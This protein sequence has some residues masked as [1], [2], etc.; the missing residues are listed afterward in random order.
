VK[1]TETFIVDLERLERQGADANLA[2]RLMRAA[3]DI[4]LAHWGLRHFT[5]K[6]PRME[7]HVQLG[8][9]RYF[10]RLQ[11][12]HLVEAMKLIAEVQASPRFLTLLAHCEPFAREAFA[13]LLNYL[14]GAPMKSEF[15]TRIKS[16]RNKAAFHYDRK[17][18]G[19][20]LESRASRP[21]SR[22]S[23]ITRASEAS[24]WRS[25]VADDIEDTILCRFLWHIPMEADVREE[26]NKIL[27][28][29]SSLCRDY[30]DVTGE[31]TF[32]FMRDTATA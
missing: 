31:L 3:D 23:S 10:V 16:I 15:D 11:C 19:A 29:A 24:M 27:D 6:Q 21:Q 18:V 12:G 28:F 8:A 4:A 25:G 30:V 1:A 22:I 5:G 17:M 20:A 13:R 26:A 32:R 2:I 14:P 7:G 9:R